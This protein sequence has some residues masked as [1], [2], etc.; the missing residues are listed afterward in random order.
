MRMKGGLRQKS[1]GFTIVETL[2]VLAITGG[3]FVSAIVM[4]SGRQ[5]QTEFNTAI[6]DVQSQLQQTISEVGNGFYPSLNNFSCSGE[7][8]GPK[9]KT[10]DSKDQ[11]SN[12]GCIFLGKVVQF[13]FAQPDKPEEYPVFSVVGLRLKGG[14]SG[15]EA[16]SV[17][18]A[19]PKVIAPA[20]GMSAGDKLVMPDVTSNNKLRGGLTVK[21]AR[22]N[23]VKSASTDVGAVGFISSL[24]SESAGGALKSGSQH[25]YALPLQGTAL[26]PADLEKAAEAINNGMVRVTTKPLGGDSL[27]ICID[28]GTT[29][30][31][32]LI[33]IGGDSR[34]LSVDL[35]IQGAECSA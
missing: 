28:S 21:W 7:L 35:R 12:K 29:A 8:I 22:I 15:P 3:L 19:Q 1:D 4:M 17:I 25:I 34:E 5:R 33:I 30:Q 32:G 23:G 16:A 10:S 18:D 24:T 26:A 2:I 11:G 31:S 20:N 9:L 27:H 14:S 6:R 13:G